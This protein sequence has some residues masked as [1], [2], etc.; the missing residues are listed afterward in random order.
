MVFITILFWTFEDNLDLVFADHDFTII[1]FKTIF[2]NNWRLINRRCNQDIFIII[3]DKNIFLC[4]SFNQ[5][6]LF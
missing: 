5:D 2:D 4:F 1:N 3:Y 6:Y